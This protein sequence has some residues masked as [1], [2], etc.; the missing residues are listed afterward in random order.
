MTFKSLSYTV[1]SEDFIL[2]FLKIN[3][4]NL[5]Q[6]CCDIHFYTSLKQNMKIFVSTMAFC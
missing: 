5:Y 4:K 2:P 1:I 6:I 3:G